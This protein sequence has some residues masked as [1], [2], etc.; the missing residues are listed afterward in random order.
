[1]PRRFLIVFGRRNFINNGGLNN[2]NLY[3][4]GWDMA[5]IDERYLNEQFFEIEDRSP[6]YDVSFLRNYERSMR[7]FSGT[8]SRIRGIYRCYALL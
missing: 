4:S 2:P 8:F 3:L 1:M 5:A 6:R 7:S